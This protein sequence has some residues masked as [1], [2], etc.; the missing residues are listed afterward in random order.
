VQAHATGRRAADRE[1][2]GLGILSAHGHP[3]LLD[4]EVIG[5]LTVEPAAA[6]APHLLRKA[7]PPLAVALAAAWTRRSEQ[8]GAAQAEVLLGLIESAARAQSMEELLGAA[9]RT[10]A[11]LD[12]VERASIF[13]LE[14][15]RLV[16]RMA[17]GADDRRDPATSEQ[18]RAAPVALEL[19][20]TVLRTGEPMTADRGS[21]L[22]AGWWADDFGIDSGLAVPLGR[23]PHVAGVLVL[24]SSQVRPFSEDVRRLAA[25]AGAHLGAVIAQTDGR[26]G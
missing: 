23:S 4:G 5:V 7:A 19:A 26:L 11:Q 17:R 20:E 3:L 21:G 15:D 2:E 12:E 22:L 9:C 16:P 13:L 24:D 25:A 18:F 1:L 8:R 14:D 6:A 10:L